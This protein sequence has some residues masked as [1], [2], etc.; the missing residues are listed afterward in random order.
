MMKCC[1]SILLFVLISISSAHAEIVKIDGISIAIRALAGYCNDSDPDILRYLEQVVVRRKP[2]ALSAPCGDIA[3]FKAGAL[4][5]LQKYIVW[6]VESTDKGTA[7]RLPP[8]I[9][10]S[11]FADGI[12]RDS[13]KLDISKVPEY[14]QSKEKLE[15]EGITVDMKSP[16]L[17]DRDPEAVYLASVV[18]MSGGA[19]S[20]P[21]AVVLGTA[22]IHH[23]SLS[24]NAYD[25]FRGNTTFSELLALVKSLM[26]GALSDNKD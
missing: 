21:I 12:A 18:N 1:A 16:G 26:R 7:F 6:S 15:K 4:G 3:A 11:E 20:K 8:A 19:V 10:R 25:I 24:I 23:L 17:I 9:T 14:L 13:Q 22:A 5:Q 2:F